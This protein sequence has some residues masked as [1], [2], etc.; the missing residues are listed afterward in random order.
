MADIK[1]K[2][3]RTLSPAGVSIN[4]TSL[5]GDSHFPYAVTV[6]SIKKMIERGVLVYEQ[7]AAAEGEEPTELLLTMENY[8]K[9]NGGEVVPENANIIP[10]IELEIEERHAAEREEWLEEKGQLIKAKQESISKEFLG[11]STSS[12]PSDD[13]EITGP[14]GSV[15]P[16]AE[17]EEE[18]EL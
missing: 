10:D 9:E 7:I 13:T 1:A 5:C 18:G 12:E 15:E 3:V 14:T 6:T 2:M 11:E 8:D 16:M 17:E 4:Y